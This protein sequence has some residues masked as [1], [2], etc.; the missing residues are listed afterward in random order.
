MP[1][2]GAD[3]ASPGAAG[4]AVRDQLGVTAYASTGHLRPRPSVRNTATSVEV[5]CWTFQ[6]RS[7]CTSLRSSAYGGG[8]CPRGE[9]DA[10]SS[11]RPADTVPDNLHLFGSCG[12]FGRAESRSRH[13]VRG[14]TVKDS[15][16]K[17]S[18]VK[19]HL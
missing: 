1:V 4:G 5:V 16:A 7:H 18:T 15:T 3:E 12:I 2:R 19:E 13:P 8:E 6:A 17:D 14:S 9:I 10:A 11:G